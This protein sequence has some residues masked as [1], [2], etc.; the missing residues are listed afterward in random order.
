MHGA[1]INQDEVEPDY[2]FPARP[3]RTREIKTD[4]LQTRMREATQKPFVG[5]TRKMRSEYSL[6]RV[7]SS[8]MNSERITD[9]IEFEMHRE[10]E[11][12]T[13]N[14]PEGM[15]VPTDLFMTRDLNVNTFG[16]GGAF[17]GTQIADEVI[18][19]LR[20]RPACVR[21]GVQ[22][23]NGLSSNVGLPRLA[24]AATVY[25]LP[26]QATLTKSTQ[27][28]DQIVLTPHRIGATTSY[29]RQLLL[30]SSVDVEA[31]LRTDLM[32]QVNIKKD[33][34][35]LNGQGANSEPTGIFNTTGIGSMIWGGAATWANVLTFENQLALSNA[36]GLPNARIGWIVSPSTRNR[37]KQIAKTGIG[38]ATTVPVF[39]W[40]ADVDYGDASND[41]KLNGYRAAV[42]NQVLNNLVFYGNWADTIL[43]GFGN[44]F[45]IISD[46]YSR[47]ADASVNV[48]INQFVDVGVRHAA[49]YIVSQ[50]AGNQ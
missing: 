46:P 13:Q 39:L 9:G 5:M 29:S 24:G 16:Q 50:D 3:K 22:E 35:V 25:S 33:F 4:Q 26:E 31:F 11:L 10:V 42:T 47:A 44:G 30:Q 19:L 40:D 15:F 17:V 2:P 45:D 6:H 18:P 49:S 43:A 38:V 8:L 12:G 20:N 32:S 1:P 7:L 23:I 34:L 48:T 36:D 27:N 14:K 28:L 21:M 37:L 41:G